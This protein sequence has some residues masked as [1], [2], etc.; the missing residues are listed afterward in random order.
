MKVW[1]LD[2]ELDEITDLDEITVGL[3]VEMKIDELVA[4]IERLQDIK[5]EL[6]IDEQTDKD[7][8]SLKKWK[9]ATK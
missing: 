4:L 7:R 2:I 8:I 1:T 5:K 6:E 3:K 9:E